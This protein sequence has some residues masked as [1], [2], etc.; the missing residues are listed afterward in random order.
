MHWFDI[1]EGI[2]DGGFPVSRKDISLMGP[3]HQIQW[4]AY[5]GKHWVGMEGIMAW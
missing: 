1:I 5:G 3:E 4:R 2:P